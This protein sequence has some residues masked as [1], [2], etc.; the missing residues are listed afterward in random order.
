MFMQMIK[1]EELNL[2]P[3]YRYR[4]ILGNEVLGNFV[5]SPKSIPPLNIRDAV[6]IQSRKNIKL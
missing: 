6:A 1:E 3:F 5:A 2:F 4:S